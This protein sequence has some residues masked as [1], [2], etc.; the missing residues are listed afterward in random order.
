MKLD[1]YEC[2][3]QM[4]LTD[5]LNNEP[6]ILL[7]IGETVYK[8]VRGDVEEMYVYNEKSWLCGENERGYRLKHH[9]GGY[10]CC[11]N[12]SIGLDVFRNY[13]EALKVANKYLETSD[14]IRAEEIKPVKT[15]AYRYTRKTDGKEMVSFYADIGNDLLYMKDFMTY[16]HICKNTK[17]SYKNL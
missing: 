16:D 10:D 5:Y 14:C 3:G 11:W 12:K 2:K 7:H 1:T 4:E 8:V 13:E 17:K 15:V 9:G 6:P